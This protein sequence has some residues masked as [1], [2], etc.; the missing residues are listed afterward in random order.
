MSTTWL[1]IIAAF[2]IALLLFLV[3]RTKIQAFL[4]LLIVSYIVGLLSGMGTTEILD[5]VSAG[6]GGTVGEIAV[7]IGVGARFGAKNG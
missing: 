5:A 2:G 4:A 6:M 3:M 7:I 1:I